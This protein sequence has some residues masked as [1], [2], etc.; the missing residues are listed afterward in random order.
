[1]QNWK[2]FIGT[3]GLC[4][5]LLAPLP[6]NAL[7]ISLPALRAGD[8]IAL[9]TPIEGTV[10]PA[11][12]VV[13]GELTYVDIEGGYY[14]VAGYRLIADEEELAAYLGQVVA[15]TG[16][17]AEDISIF[18]TKAFQVER[19]VPAAEEL[20]RITG[21]LVYEDI[22]GGY[23]AVDGYRLIGDEEEFAALLNQ[24]VVVLGTLAD[25]MSI[26]MTKAI[27]VHN[28]LGFAQ[29]EQPVFKSVEAIQARPERI[30]L[31]GVAVDLG[32]VQIAERGVLMVP[33]RAIAEAA[34]GKV[35]WF[36]NTRTARVELPDRIVSF[37]PGTGEVE[38]VGIS[39]HSVTMAMA[40]EIIGDRLHIS[41][42]ALS[43]VFGLMAMD[44]GSNE[45]SLVSRPQLEDPGPGPMDGL[46]WGSVSGTIRQIET[47]G[48]T[49]ILV[50]GETMSNGD[51]MLIWLTIA[52]DSKVLWAETQEPGSM[53]DFAIGLKIEAALTGPVLESYPAQGGTNKVTILK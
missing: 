20:L 6:A 19:L 22:E 35:A 26:Y 16:Q 17:L 33:L 5:A 34:G 44:T 48:K 4:L 28:I 7:E 15:V 24:P 12:V 43:S 18:M 31:D 49:R 8:A 23:Y 13:R 14:S 40:P 29:P 9:P 3:T 53:D 10:L 1:M 39:Q 21:D 51:P 47:Q 45:L 38:V 30:S 52:D 36:S 37:T 50:E 25:E 46:D 2:R 42:D 32:P 41:A 27:Q 11:P